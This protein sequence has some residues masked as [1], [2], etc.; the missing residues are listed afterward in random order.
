M[1]LF[2]VAE[3]DVGDALRGVGSLAKDIRSAITGEI[4]PEK[5]AEIELS[6]MKMDSVIATSQ[7]EIN[8]AEAKSASIFVAGWRPFIG[9]TGGLSLALHYIILPLLE[10]IAVL[11]GSTI[12]PPEFDLTQIIGIVVAL[13]GIGGM[14]SYDKK[15][16]TQNKH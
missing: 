6:L 5:K 11:S 12:K 2:S 13:L 9:W 14:R 16:G 3:I 1:G 8:K 7:M 10:W 4:S 15:N